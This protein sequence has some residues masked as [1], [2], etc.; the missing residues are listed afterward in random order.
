MDFK[1]FLYK[2]VKITIVIAEKPYFYT[3]QFQEDGTFVDKF[4]GTFSFSEDS[5]KR[6]EVLE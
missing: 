6:I 5:I 1:P 2:Q 4:G 3:G